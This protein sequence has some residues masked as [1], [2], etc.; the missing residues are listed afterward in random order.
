M[1]KSALKSMAIQKA[2]LSVSDKT[3]L[4]EFAQR[5]HDLGIELLSTG[6]SAK[7]IR[8]ADIPVVDVSDYTESPELFGGRVKTLHPK[9]HGGILYRRS[10]SSDVAD[11]KKHDVPA[12]DLVVVN[13][14]PFEETVTGDDV[15]LAQA[16]EKIDVGGPTMIRAAAK[17][18]EAV[19]VVVDPSDY[20]SVAEELESNDDRETSR[21]TRERLSIK[22]FQRTATYDTAISSYLNGKQ[23]TRKAFSLQLP[24][25]TELRYGENPHQ[26]AALYGNFN[27]CFTKLQGKEMSYTNVLD[28]D[29]AAAL[30]SEFSRPT[31]AILKHTNPCGVGSSEDSLRD[32]WDKAFETDK[33][34]PFGGVIVCNR[35]LD[36]SLARVISGIF[37]DIII[38]PNFDAEAR[39]ILQ[40][41]KNLRMIQMHDAYQETLSDPILR[42]APGGLLVMDSDPRVKGLGKLEEK[43]VTKR[44]PSESELKA[45]RFGMKVVKHVKSNAVIFASEDRT[46]AVGAGQMSR[47]DACRIA[48]WKANEG[49]LN[50]KGSTVASDAMFPFSDGL[51]AAADAGA[52]ACIQ[53]GGSMRDEEV[54][55]AADERAMAMVLTGHRHFLH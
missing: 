29:S 37:T 34:A 50:L 6:G 2:L 36:E 15:T 28:I 45:M 51:L 39:T 13:L 48:V 33:Q 52:T 22:A 38:A 25:A 47:V 55:A 17:N 53:P 30:I 49:G 3:G 23:A 24:L 32:A 21:A 42:S 8:E 44:P 40:K 27:E 1:Q 10:E 26:E 9:I 41:K 43:V 4:V 31:V 35:P 7:V 11:A 19:T 54:T 46:L 16:I 18:Y 20:D 14:Y 12:I 5:L